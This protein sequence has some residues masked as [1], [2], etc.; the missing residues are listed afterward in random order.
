MTHDLVTPEMMLALDALATV[1]MESDEPE[2]IRVALAALT[3]IPGGI[4]QLR[5]RGLAL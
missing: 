5:T 2:T 1:V 4:D 3:N